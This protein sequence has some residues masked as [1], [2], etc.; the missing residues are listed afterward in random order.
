MV[1]EARHDGGGGASDRWFSTRVGGVQIGAYVSEYDAPKAGMTIFWAAKLALPE[2]IQVVSEA[3]RTLG[4]SAPDRVLIAYG[5]T[6]ETHRTASLATRLAVFAA[7]PEFEAFRAEFV[8]PSGTIVAW[9]NTSD[10]NA[11]P[12]SP[13]IG[14]SIPPSMWPDFRP[15]VVHGI[16]LTT[17]L[18]G[19][20]SPAMVMGALDEMFA[21]G[22]TAH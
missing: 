2:F 5:E 10:I 18:V 19:V 12:K 16:I 8:V 21:D 17:P 1:D 4:A 7:R 20:T 22:A 13:N 15:V 14:I 9:A 11:A 6:K 3:E